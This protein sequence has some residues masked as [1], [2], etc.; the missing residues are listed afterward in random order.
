MVF[1]N[2]EFFFFFFNGRAE[3]NGLEQIKRMLKT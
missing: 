1:L 3:S 2:F